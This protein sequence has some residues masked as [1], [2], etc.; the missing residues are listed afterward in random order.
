MHEYDNIY[1]FHGHQRDRAASRRF[2]STLAQCHPHATYCLAGVVLTPSFLSLSLI[3]CPS[4]AVLQPN[5]TRHPLLLVHWGNEHHPRSPVLPV[6]ATNHF[7][8]AF[9]PTSLTS[10]Q[11]RRGAIRCAT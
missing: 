7:I 3:S 1:L 8:P 2:H 5:S 9:L 4:L 11:D 6:P 10:V